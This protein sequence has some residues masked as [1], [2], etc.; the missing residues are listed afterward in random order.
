[1]STLRSKFNY[2]DLSSSARKVRRMFVPL[3]L[4]HFSL[5]WLLLH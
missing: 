2:T 3:W 4:L 5:A 1:M